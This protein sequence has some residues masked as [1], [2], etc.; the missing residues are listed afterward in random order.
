MTLVGNPLVDF[1]NVQKANGVGR[2][3][4]HQI[5]FDPKVVNPL[6]YH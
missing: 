1:T 2:M 5:F 3:R 4:P 6:G